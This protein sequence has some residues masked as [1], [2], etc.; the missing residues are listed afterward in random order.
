MVGTHF[1]TFRIVPKK[2]S[3]SKSNQFYFKYKRLFDSNVV[4]CQWNNWP[5]K[6]YRLLRLRFKFGCRE[7][8]KVLPK[9]CER[10]RAI[11]EALRFRAFEIV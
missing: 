1:S 7:K 9:H 4:Q 10:D 5:Y 2:K 8:C 11:A 6:R 3:K